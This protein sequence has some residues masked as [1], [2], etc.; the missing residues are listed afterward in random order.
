MQTGFY[1][2]VTT[3]SACLIAGCTGYTSTVNLDEM[4]TAKD[5]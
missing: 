2:V 5:A 4:P 1:G 3:V